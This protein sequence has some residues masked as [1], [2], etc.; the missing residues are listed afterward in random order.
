MHY[1]GVVGVRGLLQLAI[2]E[3]VLV[4]Q[5][6]VQLSAIFFEPGSAAQV[7]AELR[8]LG[9][10]VVGLAGPVSSISAS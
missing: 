9:D 10:V 8:G 6:P 7:A 3:E 5:P 4:D 2:M 1:C